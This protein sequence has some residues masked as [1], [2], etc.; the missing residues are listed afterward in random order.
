MK[1]KDYLLNIIAPPRCMSCNTRMPLDSNALFCF[2][3][4]KQYKRNDQNTCSICGKPISENSDKTCRDCKSTKIYYVKNVSRYLYKGCIKNAIQN[5]KFKNRMWI[6]YEFGKVLCDTVKNEYGDIDFDMVLYVPMTPIS[7]RVRGFNQSAEIAQVI[8]E[9]LNIPIYDKILYKKAGVKTQSGLN[10]KDRIENIKNAFIV[11]HSDLLVDKTI[12][13]IDDVFTTGSTVNE[14]AR[15]LKKNGALAVY[16]A[17]VA[18][19]K[20]D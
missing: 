3:C 13:L 11:R 15:T 14:C 12:L 7:K 20:L 1:L 18:T 5:M 2:E 9:K 4:S 10:R 6:A 17:T 19:V 8:S 16:T